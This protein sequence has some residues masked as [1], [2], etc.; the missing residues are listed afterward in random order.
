MSASG[1]RLRV[2]AA[3]AL[4]PILGAAAA[5][6]FWNLDIGIPHRVGVDE[7]VIAERAIG[8]MRTGDFNP[9]FFDYPGLYIYLQLL[10]ALV[11]FISGA[12]EGL[13][14]TLQQFGDEHL[15]LWTRAVNAA[16]GT[17]T[18]L[19]V[20]LAGRRWGVGSA[21]LAAAL[22][23]VFPNHVRESHFALTDVPV[24]FMAAL[25]FL[26]TLRAHETGA[27][28]RFVVAGAAAGL[29]AA[30]KY[31]GGVVL[32]LP[33]VAALMTPSARPS[34]AAAAG[35]AVAACL[36]AFLLGAPYTV[37]DLPAFLDAYA[38]LGRS[39]RPRSFGSGWTIYT[40]HLRLSVS[41]VGVVALAAG[42]GLAVAR[43]VRGPE[44]I[45]W[46]LLTA[47]LPVYGYII[48]TSELVYARY[49]LPIVP[50]LCL[51]A[52]QP[53]DLAGRWLARRLATGRWDAAVVAG[54][55]I[56]LLA[57]PAHRSVS[58]CLEHG[59]PTTGDMAYAVLNKTVPEHAGVVVE[60][61][62][63][64]LPASRFRGVYVRE[65]VQQP[66]AAYL[67]AGLTYAV[68]SS[69]AFGPVLADPAGH[70]A[71]AESYQRLF[72]EWHL[73]MQIKPTPAR[74]GPEIRIYRLG[75]P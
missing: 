12:T 62:A 29:T 35:A 45:R 64:R 52:A 49:L 15:Y 68:A 14:Y 74:P 18:V 44:R 39:Y 19:L 24:T 50:L 46:V 27:L 55:W 42:V 43:I 51:V 30:T 31:N 36:A 59:R 20:Y 9:H 71:A 60:H 10:I 63:L 22:M 70:G 61:F 26:L 57:Y 16:L 21:L 48:A 23:A 72:D 58:W 7:P 47:M 5:L 11:R 32:L 28:T 3:W 56:L 40:Q 6:R 37:L 67:E 25:T 54:V 38:Y 66:T 4:V 65:L 1:S 75:K 13:W 69:E 33:V 8:M 73:V 53:V 34:R 41:W 17:A 2:S